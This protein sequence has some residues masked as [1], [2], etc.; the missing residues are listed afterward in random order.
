[1]TNFDEIYHL[2]F[3]D[4]YKY[5]LTL[6][7]NE[8]VAEEIT[9]ETFFKALKNINHFNGSCKI[10]VWLCQIAKNTY[11][12]FYQKEKKNSKKSVI[13]FEESYNFEVKLIG[14]EEAFVIHKVL[15]SI[16]EPYKEVFTLRTFGELSFNKIGEL[17]GKTD[18]WA[19]VTYYRAK[20]KIQEELL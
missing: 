20:I 1:M 2:Y 15:H 12:T 16:D 4:V 3:D 19:R 6:S 18:V 13:E 7:R 9:Q 8:T 11:F 14:E 17:F 10:Y 5:V